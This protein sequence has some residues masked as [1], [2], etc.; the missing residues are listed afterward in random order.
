MVMVVERGAP[1]E[2]TYEHYRL[3]I[4][5]RISFF[6]IYTLTNTQAQLRHI[7]SLSGR[8]ASEVEAAGEMTRALRLELAALLEQQ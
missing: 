8:S 1:S 6:H 5:Y 4:D 2:Y 7:S 3:T